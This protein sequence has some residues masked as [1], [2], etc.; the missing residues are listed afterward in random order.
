VHTAVL[1]EVNTLLYMLN[2]LLDVTVCI[3]HCLVWS[4]RTVHR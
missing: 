2:I 4:Y 1:A 3:M